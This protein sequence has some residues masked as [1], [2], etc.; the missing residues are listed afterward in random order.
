MM[1]GHTDPSASASANTRPRRLN[2]SGVRNRSFFESW[3]SLTEW[4]GFVPGGIISQD[5]ARV[6]ILD[7]T[8]TT[9]LA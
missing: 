8:C 2:S 1:P 4:H 6:I 7:N 3:Y 5:C 9:W